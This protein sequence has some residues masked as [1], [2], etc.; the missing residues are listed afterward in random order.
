MENSEMHSE[1]DKALSDKDM[2]RK[3]KTPAQIQALERVYNEHKYPTET[4]TMEVASSFGL[5]EKQVSGWFCQRRSK[6]RRS[7]NVENNETAQKQDLSTGVVEQ[8]SCG[9]T[10]QTCNK[11]SDTRE[12]ES[13][14]LTPKHAG[15]YKF[16][17]EGSSGS[18][19]SLRDR[20][21]KPQS[22]LTPGH[23]MASRHPVPSFTPDDGEIRRRTGPSGYLKVKGRAENSAITEVKKRMGNSYRTDGPPLAV[24]F[25]TLPPHPFEFPMQDINRDETGCA[26]ETVSPT[27]HDTSTKFDEGR[28]E[29]RF[30]AKQSVQEFV[31]IVE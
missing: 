15:D 26:E 5:T 2:K 16:A 7:K 22:S 8:D 28:S 30:K 10:K 3:V 27:L 14:R 1:E 6:D 21:N 23:V 17:T 25:D 4:M 11:K 18:N 20:C 9:S 19:S 12:V 31:V 24:E 13:G 29:T